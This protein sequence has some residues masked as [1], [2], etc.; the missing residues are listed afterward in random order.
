MLALK[1]TPPPPGDCCECGERIPG[2]ESEVVLMYNPNGARL[3]FHG[4][5]ALAA[6]EAAVAAPEEWVMGLRF[7]REPSEAR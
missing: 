5:C 4:N 3:H 2:S 1:L 6:Y 7:A